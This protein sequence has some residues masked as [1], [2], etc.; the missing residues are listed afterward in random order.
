MV[1]AHDLLVED[2]RLG[3]LV[4]LGTVGFVLLIACANVAN[5]LLVRATARRGEI[6]IRAALGAGR[7][8]LIRQLLTESVLLALSAARS[9]CSWRGGCWGC[10]FASARRIS[11]DRPGEHRYD[12]PVVRHRRRGVDRCRVRHRAGATGVRVEPHRRNA[13]RAGFGAIEGARSSS[14]RR[15]LCRSIL[16]AG[17]GLMIR[18]F[19]SS[20]I[21]I[22]GSSR[23]RSDRADL[24]AG[25]SLPDRPG[26]VPAAV[27]PGVTP[28]LS[29][30]SAFYTRLMENAGRD[31]RHPISGRRDVAAAESGR[32]RLRFAGRRPGTATPA[33][34]RRA[35]GRLPHRHDR[36]FPHDADSAPE[37]PAFTE[38]DGPD[39]TPVVI[40][41]DTMARQMF[42]GED[43]LG[44]RL[45]LY[46]RPREIVGLVGSVR[47]HGFSR[48]PRPEMILPYRQ[49]Q[50]GGMTIVVRSSLEPSALAAA[51]TREVHAID[52]EL[53]VS[54]VRTMAGVS[55]A[56]WRSRDSRRC[57]SRAS[58]ARDG[59]G[60]R[61]RLRRDVIHRQSAD[62]GDR[63]AHGV[64]RGPARTWCGW[65]CATA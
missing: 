59:A 50:L 33:R 38:F 11:R 46:G 6:A 12:R 21:S 53:P 44:Q 25:Q 9:A 17:A 37:R 13:R 4:L 15:L 10:S 60:A 28:Q 3:L 48:E 1:G 55:S 20:R 7:L 27:Q 29:K 63:R 65:S 30:P 64:G 42:P 31:A 32:H 43:P 51:I 62:A 39:A 52:P 40:I 19:S 5:L 36:L 57:S 2:V 45:L 49:F 18:S 56:P 47:H 61:R 54:R 16:L 26:A 58:R 35:A 23:E 22:S 41:N 34:G 14:F 8:R 24:P